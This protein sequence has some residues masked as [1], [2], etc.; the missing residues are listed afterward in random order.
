MLLIAY[1]E[2]RT[3]ASSAFPQENRKNRLPGAHPGLKRR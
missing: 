3:A 1:Y 2:G